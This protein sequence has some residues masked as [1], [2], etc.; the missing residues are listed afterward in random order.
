MTLRRIHI[1]GG[2]G[3]GKT[4]AGRR[5]AT[6]LHLPFHE[7][8][9]IPIDLDWDM[10]RAAEENTAERI[11]EQDA[12]LSEGA[13]FGWAQPLLDRAELVVLLDLPWRVASYR[14]ITRYF[15]AELARNNQHHG[16]GRLKSFWTWSRRYYRDANP[17]TLNNEGVPRTRGRAIE[18]LSP[19]REKLRVCRSNH[20]VDLLLR[21]IVNPSMPIA[22]S[23]APPPPTSNL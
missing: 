18:E 2:P 15:K 5:I 11:A 13:Y 3:S 6:E 17:H 9:Q 21:Q 20:E 10:A 12:W 23:V 8:D 22:A 19:Y 14:I 16:L 7:L 1:T 4:T